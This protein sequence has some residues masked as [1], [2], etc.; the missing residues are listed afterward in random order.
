MTIHKS[1]GSEW[2][3]VL[4]VASSSHWIMHDRN[5]LYTGASRSAESLMILGDAIG[6]AHF[7]HERKS[8]TRQTF[9]AFLVHGWIPR[10][11]DPLSAVPPAP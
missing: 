9:G 6:L 3:F 4:L 10:G 11:R 5:L 8:E 1:Q 2:P 7:A